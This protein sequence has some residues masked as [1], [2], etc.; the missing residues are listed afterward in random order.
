VGE[1]Q[2]IDPLVL[3]SGGDVE[4]PEDWASANGYTLGGGSVVG[5]FVMP[6]FGF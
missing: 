5:G 2:G 4:A 3:D 6:L 1:E